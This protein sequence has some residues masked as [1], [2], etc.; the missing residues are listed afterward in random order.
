MGAAPGLGAQGAMPGTLPMPAPPF[1]ARCFSRSS[2]PNA[3]TVWKQIG[4]TPS[5]PGTGHAAR[6]DMLVAGCLH[7]LEALLNHLT[8]SFVSLSS[9][10]ERKKSLSIGRKTIHSSKAAEPY[11]RV[12]LFRVFFKKIF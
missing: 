12:S 10:K 7:H 11:G 1:S 9:T 8:A 3:V 6:R 2:V 5:P 4:C